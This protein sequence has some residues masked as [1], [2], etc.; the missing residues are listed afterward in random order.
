MKQIKIALVCAGLL[1][2][3][4]ISAQEQK[5]DSTLN[6]TVVVENQYNPEV[7]DAF[8]VNVL[9]KVEE[10]AVAKKNIDYAT[11]LRPLTSWTVRP[12]DSFT[13]DLEWKKAPRGYIR[14]AYGSR[15]NAD[16]KASYLWDITDRD[17]LD[18]MASLYGFSGDVHV[19]GISSDWKA[20]F[21]RT[22]LSAVYTHAFRKV[23]FRLGGSFASQVFNHYSM[24]LEVSSATQ[25]G[26]DF[27]GHQHYTLGEGF[28]GFRSNTEDLPVQFD[29][30]TGYRRFNRK[31]AVPNL[32]DGAEN[33]IHTAAHV[34]GHLNEEQ[35]VGVG[36]TMDNL[37]YDSQNMKNYTS[38]EANPYYAYDGD[39]WKLRL[40]VHVDWQSANGSGVDVAPD[41]KV[42]YVFS[43]SYVIYA[44]A[45]GGRE[46]NDFRRLNELSPYWGQKEQLRSTYTLA[47]MQLGFKA[48]PVTGLGLKVFGGY[49]IT[50]DEVF[51]C[52]PLPDF[53]CALPWMMQDKAKVGY[54]GA[55][56]EYGYKDWADFSLEGIYYSWD[57]ESGSEYPLLMY[58]PE[59]ALNFHARVRVFAGLHVG[60]DYQYEGRKEAMKGYKAD[61][62]NNLCLNAEYGWKKGVNVFVRFNNL[63]NKNYI[64]QTGYPEQG[65]YAMGGISWI[66]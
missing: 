23:D 2:G 18:V 14:G 30:Q 19:D 50:D 66:F 29:V 20:R 65:F 48:S 16:L 64:T 6:R 12:M 34:W 9:P 62:V 32:T 54:G 52:Y 44:Q 58:K 17:R 37:S 1:P 39:N 22:D 35:Q 41:V 31:Y 40:G 27:A 4:V 8:K 46:L 38:L 11:S 3:A 21:Y 7:M 55:R 51:T 60:L 5:K 25:E 45:L 53:A 47:D 57:T 59:L 33:E 24:P 15:N 26:A 28:L 42:D 10:P 49:R 61:P 43:D 13:R 56:L 36:I 63:L